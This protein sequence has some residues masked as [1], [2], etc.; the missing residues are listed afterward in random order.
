MFLNNFVHIQHHFEEQ[1][2]ANCNP[3]I[4][5]LVSILQNPSSVNSSMMYPSK[6][7]TAAV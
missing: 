2:S 6:A 3:S 1:N 4:A 5:M 7:C